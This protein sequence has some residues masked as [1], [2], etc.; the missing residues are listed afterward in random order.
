MTGTQIETHL[1]VLVPASLFSC[2]GASMNQYP[3]THNALSVGI[4]QYTYPIQI[5]NVKDGDTITGKIDLGFAI[6]KETII[7]LADINAPE[8][9]GETKEAGLLAREH[10]KE[11]LV[12]YA[13]ISIQTVK[14]KKGTR[15]KKGKYGRYLGFLYG[16]ICPLNISMHDSQ[17]IVREANININYLMVEHGYAK[18]KKYA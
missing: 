17:E 5:L 13:P 15:D 9:R 11:L 2:T 4:T 12:E 7:R 18:L 10:L 1:F 8:K 3:S 14:Y 6:Y 16:S